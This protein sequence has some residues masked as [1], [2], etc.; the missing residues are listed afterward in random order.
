MN[1]MLLILPAALLVP[2]FAFGKTAARSPG[3]G[4][5]G[6]AISGLRGALDVPALC[7]EK[8]ASVFH[9]PLR[10]GSFDAVFDG[11]PRT[12]VR[13]GAGEA[14]VQGA[15]DPPRAGGEIDRGLA[16]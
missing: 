12:A 9:T 7:R 8:R 1:K 16:R 13:T 4:G 11:N 3:A 5:S 10:E 2:A 14:V 6:A 15:P